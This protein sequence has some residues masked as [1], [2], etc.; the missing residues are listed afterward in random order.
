MQTAGQRGPLRDP[1]LLVLVAIL[2]V[3]VVATLALASR[4]S[5]SAG[6]QKAAVGEIYQLQA[7]FHRAKTTQDIDL[8]LSLWGPDAVIHANGKEIKGMDAIRAY[9]LASPSFKQHRFSLVPSFKEVIQPKG[10]AAYLYFECHDVS[11]FDQPTRA[12]AGDTFLAG[13]VH[14]ENGKWVFYDMTAGSAAPF[15]IDHYYF[16]AP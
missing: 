5:A 3:A 1:R 6:D 12:I 8:M 14:F 13:T 4:S 11:D 2:I 16:P 9:W 15:S 10:D 7:A